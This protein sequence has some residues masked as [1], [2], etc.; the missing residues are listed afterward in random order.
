MRLDAK[1]I[2]LYI[3]AL[4]SGQN[5]LIAHCAEIFE[6]YETA[7][8]FYEKDGM[9]PR[10]ANLAYKTNDKKRAVDLLVK[11]NFIKEA[12][13]VSREAG[14]YWPAQATAA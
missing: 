13:D 6:D 8:D 12:R 7:I 14:G 9:L 11:G 3:R 2:E 5:G 4:K 10:A 1:S